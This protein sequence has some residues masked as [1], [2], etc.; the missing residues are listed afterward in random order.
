[1]YDCVTSDFVTGDVSPAIVSWVIIYC[2]Y[3]ARD[4]WP[5]RIEIS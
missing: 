5:E 4:I 1:M 2:D 3:I